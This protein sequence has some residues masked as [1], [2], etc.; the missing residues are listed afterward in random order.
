MSKYYDKTAASF[1]SVTID[2]KTLDAQK[3][4]VKPKN[5]GI[6]DRVDITELISSTETALSYIETKQYTTILEDEATASGEFDA[7]HFK[8]QDVPHDFSIKKFILKPLESKNTPLYMAVWTLTESGQKTYVGLSDEAITWEAGKDAVWTFNNVELIVP[9]NHNV[10]FFLCTGADAVGETNANAPGVYIKTKYNPSGR[11]TI[12]YANGWHSRCVQATF[13]NNG[14]LSHVGD[15]SHLTSEQKNAISDYI[16]SKSSLDSIQEQ[17][18]TN[19]ESI[20]YL[21]NEFNSVFTYEEGSFDTNTMA[22]TLDNAT[23]YGIQYSKEHFGVSNVSLRKISIPYNAVTAVTSTGYLAVQIFDTNSQ[24]ITS[25]YSQNTHTFSNAG[26]AEFSFINVTI[27]ESYKFIRFILVADKSVELPTSY[28]SINSNCLSFR[29]SPIKVSDS[30]TFD[31]DDCLT[32]S[33]QSTGTQN[34]LI[35]MTIDYKQIEKNINKISQEVEEVKSQVS[36]KKGY[37]DYSAPEYLTGFTNDT[38]TILYGTQ[39]VTAPYDCMASIKIG[40]LKNNSDTFTFAVGYLYVDGFYVGDIICHATTDASMIM[41]CGST[42]L[43]PVKSGQ[44]IKVQ[45]GDAVGVTIAVFPWN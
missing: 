2:T 32:Y 30:F 29:G 23:I 16:N 27:P 3:I 26:P 43:L 40:R 42:Q 8:Y 11:G 18:N 21:H 39:T 12:H 24:L 6:N 7:V 10:E 33:N 31:E 9:E 14:Y 34:W 5:G 20:E 36:L 44:T 25:Y 41:Y 4:L 35:G 19:T 17:I 13:S 22:G 1:K 28:N 15:G 38:P 37:V 45:V